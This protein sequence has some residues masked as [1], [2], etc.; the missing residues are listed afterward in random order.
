MQKRRY[1][2][3][4]IVAA[5]ALVL[6][7]CGQPDVA[8]QATAVADASLSAAASVAATPTAAAPS[9]AASEAAQPTATLV[10]AASASSA[11][12]PTLAVIAT[13][14]AAPTEA[15]T[16]TLG[17]VSGAGAGGANEIETHF[18][19]TLAGAI[20]GKDPSERALTRYDDKLSGTYFYTQNNAG[21]GAEPVSLLIDGT[22]GADGQVALAEYDADKQTGAF[23]GV[24]AQASDGG[25]PVITLTGTWTKAGTTQPLPFTVTEQ[26]VRIGEAGA[27]LSDVVTHTEDMERK[28]TYDG[29]YP[30]I[31]GGPD[32]GFNAASAALVTDSLA[33]FR[34]EIGQYLTDIP[35]PSDSFGSSIDVGYEVAATTP[36]LVSILFNQ[37][38]YSAGAA[39]PNHVSYPL[40]YDLAAGRTLELGDLFMPGSDYLGTLSTYAVAEINT[41]DLSPFLEGADPKPENYK[42]WNLQA[43]GLRITFDPYQVAAYAAGPQT[44]VVPWAELQSIL[45]ADGP[46]AAFAK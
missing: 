33:A 14:T 4:V 45:R 41:R 40:N 9:E 6:G 20:D 8:G 25:I 1:R 19:K 32:V 46:A 10:P 44:V 12:A 17:G 42:S 28:V 11:P 24:L 13:P 35:Q 43:D 15:P 23:A 38:T 34:T 29:V 22:V 27:Y 39:H 7:A 30:A 18:N 31:M 2:R 21:T 5:A 26:I 36:Q 37:M 3:V 16:A